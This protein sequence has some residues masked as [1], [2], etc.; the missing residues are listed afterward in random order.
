VDNALLMRDVNGLRQRHDERRGSARRE[1]LGA[2]LQ[3]AALDKLQRKVELPGF[4][5]ELIEL[6]DVGMLKLGQGVR[7]D[8]K[9]CPVLRVGLP[10]PEKH[11]EG[12]PAPYGGIVR[13]V[14]DPHAAASDFADDLIPAD[15]DRHRR[16]GKRWLG[17]MRTACK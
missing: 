9:A 4:V 1:V 8:T 3:R 14:D 10:R 15:V 7:F 16:Q 2:S 17:V 5:T 6:H 11:L 13:L 12:N